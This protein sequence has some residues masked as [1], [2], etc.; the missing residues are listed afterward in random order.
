MKP[1]LYLQLEGLALPHIEAY[2]ADLT[3]HDRKS[4]E[5]N[6][7]IPFLHF[8][9]SCGTY[10]VPMFPA[11]HESWPAHGEI[12]PYLFGRADRWHIL[13]GTL[14]VVEHVVCREDSDRRKSALH[15]DGKRLKKVSLKRAHEI[16]QE[17]VRQVE[18]AW[19]GNLAK[20]PYTDSDYQE[21]PLRVAY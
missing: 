21:S 4:I 17:Y 3:T 5:D 1:N 16:A 15:Y 20:K 2:H 19:R 11:N 9:G 6:P 13:K 8:T 18:K 7:G 10:M 12:V 14:V